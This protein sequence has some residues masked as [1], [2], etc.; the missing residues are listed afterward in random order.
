MPARKIFLQ[1]LEAATKNGPDSVCLKIGT[2]VPRLN[3]G[4]GF[5]SCWGRP[6]DSICWGTPQFVLLPP[7]FLMP[8]K[9]L[10]RVTLCPAETWDWG[11]AGQAVWVT[12][13]LTQM[14]CPPCKSASRGA[15]NT[16]KGEFSPPAW[17][18]E[19]FG[20]DAS[21]SRGRTL[22]DPK[23]D[24]CWPPTT[25]SLHCQ[26][27]NDVQRLLGFLLQQLREFWS[28]WTLADIPI[29]FSLF[30]HKSIPFRRWQGVFALA[31][32]KTM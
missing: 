28:H 11:G 18:R 14:R 19:E 4:W 24:L 7:F 5:Q 16:P 1:L 8:H 3:Q 15:R 27:A 23:G 31:L 20:R 29:G 32:V 12:S 6:W 30:E 9:I 26:P 22:L 13:P 10:L 21:G 25:S 17:E 2:L